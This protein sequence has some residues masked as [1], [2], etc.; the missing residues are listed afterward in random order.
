MEEGV[1]EDIFV[2]V[3]PS[4]IATALLLSAL[5]AVPVRKAPRAPRGVV[6]VPS[7]WLSK[8]P[9]APS[10]PPID[11]GRRA[12]DS[13]RL[14]EIPAPETFTVMDPAPTAAP[15]AGPVW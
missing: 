7:L 15:T 6:T 1:E 9:S 5:P 13:G 2:L 11:P 8:D 14:P 12:R 10:A 3:F 4:P